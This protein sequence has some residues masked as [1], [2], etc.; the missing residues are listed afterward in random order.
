MPKALM[1]ALSTGLALILAP[2]AI[3]QNYPVTKTTDTN[4]GTCDSDCS[5]REAIIAANANAGPDVI[6][7]PAGT[8]LRGMQTA[9]EDL[10][11]S[12]DLDITDDVSIVGAGAR[13][14]VISASDGTA[15][16]ST[17]RVFDVLGG[18]VSMSGITISGGRATGDVG[19][20][21]ENLAML[22]LTDVTVA[23][24]KATES[25]GF[26]GAGAGIYNEGTLTANGG[27]LSK[28]TASSNGG[29]ITNYGTVTATNV[30]VSG[31]KAYYDGGGVDNEA[32]TA[33]VTNAT[34]AGNDAGGAV[35]GTP[36]AGG[37]VFNAG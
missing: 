13:T 36:G 21:I 12:G 10:S 19:G 23:H 7:V 1:A 24:N 34:I 31:N 20:G 29:G 26:G 8:Y 37:G 11:A 18:S 6:T 16:L 27:A 4:D 33:T 3:A 22:T 5:L 32:G 25:G 2:A 14:T 28:N 9:G 30:T 35:D 17:D 15:N